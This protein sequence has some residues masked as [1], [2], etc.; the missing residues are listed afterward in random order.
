M[1]DHSIVGAEVDYDILFFARLPGEADNV[2]AGFLINIEAQNDSNPE[3][4]LLSRAVYYVC[5]ILAGEKN[6]V[7]VEN[8]S[9]EYQKVYSMWICIGHPN[10]KDGVINKYTLNE[11]CLG[12]EWHSPMMYYDLITVV[13][14]YPKKHYDYNDTSDKSTMNYGAYYLNQSY[15]RKK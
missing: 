14:I 11:T 3:Y 12:R 13:M 1:E 2:K 10:Y 5:R 7:I 15:H 6:G 8:Q 9:M 4:P